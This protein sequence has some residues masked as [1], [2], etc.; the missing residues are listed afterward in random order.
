MDKHSRLFANVTATEIKK[1]LSD[2]T[3]QK[4]FFSAL[5]DGSTLETQKKKQ[6]ITA[7]LDED[8]APKADVVATL[9]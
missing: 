5:N 6:D 2:A 3:D 7:L 4:R 9:F 1:Y 8:A